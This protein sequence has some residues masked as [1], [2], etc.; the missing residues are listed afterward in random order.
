MLCSGP[1]CGGCCCHRFYLLFL[2]DFFLFVRSFVVVVL[3][4]FLSSFLSHSMAIRW[5]WFARPP[6]HLS[7]PTDDLL[8]FTG[9][10]STVNIKDL[11]K[12]KA[13]TVQPSFLLLCDMNG[14]RT[15][16]NLELSSL[17]QPSKSRTLINFNYVQ[18][19]QVFD[20]NTTARERQPSD[21]K[22]K[23]RYID[24]EREWMQTLVTQK[25]HAINDAMSN[26]PK[27]FYFS[28]L[29]PQWAL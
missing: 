24:G 23:Q 1:W 10:R 17:Q 7:Q 3:S 25:Q 28:L 20:V 13:T 22:S 21:Q 8:V 15:Y 9:V 2:F 27:R 26:A 12:K 19:E 6:Q 14:A 16:C 5:R 29:L 4:F 18:I 11:T